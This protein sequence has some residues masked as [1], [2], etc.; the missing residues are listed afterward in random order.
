[1]PNFSSSLFDLHSLN[2]SNSFS[3]LDN[4]NDSTNP[5]S[6]PGPPLA[7]SSPSRNRNRKTFKP[8]KPLRI[9]NINFQSL[10]SKKKGFDHLLDR[11][12]P[13]I[14]FGTESWLGNTVKDH[15]VFPDGYS[16][17]RKDRKQVTGKKKKAGGGVFVAVRDIM[18]STQISDFQTDCEIVWAKIS[19]A[20]SKNL[21]V[22]SYYRPHSDDQYSLDQLA[23]SLDK[24]P[25]DGCHVWLAGDMNLPGIDWTNGALKSNCPTPSQHIQ[26][27]DMMA[28]N[29]LVQ[30]VEEPTRGNNT[31]D[32][33]AVNNPTRVNRI[34]LMP[35]LSDHDIVFA[36]IDLTPKKRHQVKRQIPLYN[37]ADWEGIAKEMRETQQKMVI[38]YENADADTLWNCFKTSLQ[39]A[40]RKCIPHRP[41]S[42]RD[43]PPWISTKSKKL[44]KARDHL[45][46]KFQ[47]HPTESRKNNLKSLKK[48]IQKTTK[49][50][51]W[52][53]TEN[54]LTEDGNQSN[55]KKLWTFIKHK[56][57]DSIDIAPLKENGI[58]KDAPKDKARILNK[59][60]SSV[61]TTDSPDQFP[62]K[63]IWH[64]EKKYPD[65]KNI[66]VTVE[67]VE[68]LLNG[69]NPHKAMGPD[70]LHPKV[71][72]QLCSTI[73]PMLQAIFQKS[74]DTSQVPEDW[75]TANVCPIYK[76]GER[77]EP[78]NY[79]PVSLT[80]VCS[81]L[82][83]HIVAKHILGHLEDHNILYDLQ[84]G[85]R[86]K[87]STET[88]LLA[89][90]Q[91]VLG[92]LRGNQQTDMIIMDFAKAFDKVSHWRLAIKL[93]NYGV[94]GRLNGWIKSF[95]SQRSQRVV[96]GGEY[97]ESAPVLS[98]VPQGSV[99]GPLLFLVYIND[100][101]DD[102]RS[103]V[104]LFADDTIVYL[105][106]NCEADATNL[107]EDLDKLAA[108]EEKWQMSFHPKKC[109]VIR[110]TRKRSPKIFDYKLHGHILQS[111]T[112]SKY[113]GVTINNKLSWNNHIDNTTKKANASLAFLRR[114]LQISQHHIKERAYTTLVRPQLEY[115][116]SVWDP[117][118]KQKQKQIEMVQ[119]RAARF[120]YRN[121][122]REASVTAMIEKLKWRSL[123][124]RRADIRLIMMY[125]CL[126]GLVA[127]DLSQDLIPQS[128]PSRHCNSMSFHIPSETKQYIQQSFLPRTIIQWNHL[129]EKLALAPS[130][131]AFKAGVSGLTH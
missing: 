62:D 13:D 21:Y 45:F 72:K 37:K 78:E 39:A 130:L 124:Q 56:K 96:C 129:P 73:A 121:Y 12:K 131:D 31:L 30:V 34:E 70:S 59:Q 117:Y 22:A 6:P 27:M 4:T 111:E 20:G 116:A 105:T 125:K 76:K 53:Y 106:M 100:L 25:K 38:M 107:Q 49:E 120:V 113:L 16:V 9:L 2:S 41:S 7:S 74:L 115:A 90:T 119:R 58:L 77:Y 19:L 67:G 15:E 66:K 14:I 69:L 47:S 128:R 36:E 87:R 127:V 33:V 3:I 91:D 75:R 109:S 88:Q 35:A 52:R 44:I 23:E 93:Q 10:I 104:R 64:T 28:D 126:N 123:M 43:R 51:Y 17:Y 86:S 24:L 103:T 71:L 84:H 11:T 32:L 89:F 97:S 8:T 61:F 57:T 1:M 18:L 81:K 99:L 108:W 80:C 40:I 118:T 83:E 65:I 82:M 5:P 60:F 122:S 42:S 54:M 110:I 98:G 95:L 29:G 68:K 114:N 46:K 26:F 50:D 79:R 94:S 63:S 85:F 48:R 55:N 102:V 101:P 92:N 112:D